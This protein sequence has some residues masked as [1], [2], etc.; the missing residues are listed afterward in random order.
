M[1]FS[2]FKDRENV[3][4]TYHEKRKNIVNQVPDNRTNEKDVWKTIRV[5]EHFL[6][7]LLE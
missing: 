3:L 6:S 2:H 1:K 7:T 4:K 5:S